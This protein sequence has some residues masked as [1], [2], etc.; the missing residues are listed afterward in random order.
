M[1]EGGNE[2]GA[3]IYE[4]FEDVP[5]MIQQQVAM[6]RMVEAKTFIPEVGSRVN[7]REF[8]VQIDQNKNNSSNA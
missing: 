5:P 6:L 2:P 7:E 4:R 1:P 3:T 8:W